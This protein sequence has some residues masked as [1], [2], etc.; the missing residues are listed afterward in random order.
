ML[1]PDYQGGDGELLWSIYYGDYAM[2]KRFDAFRNAQ[3]WDA[4]V[5]RPMIV[6]D[7]EFARF[8]TVS[9]SSSS[10]NAGSHQWMILAAA[11]VVIVAAFAMWLKQRN[12]YQKIVDPVETKAL[13]ES[14]GN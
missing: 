13:L 4:D 14:Y 9:K 10:S 2:D 5:I 6:D 11:A 1:H 3:M 7:V 8:Q 12:S